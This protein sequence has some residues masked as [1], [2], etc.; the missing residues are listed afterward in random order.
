MKLKSTLLLV[1]CSI[2]ISLNP[3]G[4]ITNV[5]SAPQNLILKEQLA[6]FNMEALGPITVSEFLSISPKQYRGISGEKLKFKDRFLLKFA[7]KS[8]KRQLKNGDTIS[9]EDA[10]YDF[11][12]GGFLLGFF[13]GLLGVLIALLLFPNNVFRSS[14]LGLLCLI[15]ALLVGLVIV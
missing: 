9:F 3:L 8:L 14:L 5:E 15:I 13:L 6:L 11:S 4:A 7:Q 10:S 2:L 12:V 1:T